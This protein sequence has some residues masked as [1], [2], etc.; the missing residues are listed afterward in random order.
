MFAMDPENRPVTH[1]GCDS[2]SIY[3]HKND[4]CVCQKGKIANICVCIF[5][6]FFICF[7]YLLLTDSGSSSQD[8]KKQKKNPKTNLIKK[9]NK[10]IYIYICIG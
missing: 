5:I 1:S 7:I 9:I 2:I 10:Y 4:N 6:Y 3:T 8:L